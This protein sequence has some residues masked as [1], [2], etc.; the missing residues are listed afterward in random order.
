MTLTP[1]RIAEDRRTL[2]DRWYAEGFYGAQTLGQQFLE[3]VEA[4][5]DASYI[6]AGEQDEQALSLEAIAADAIR[7]CLGLRALGVR[8]GDVVAVQVPNRVELV[9][10]YYG[11]WLAGAVVVPITHIYGPMEMSFILRESG[12]KVL[13]VPDRWHHIDFVERISGLEPLPA[14]E[15]VV[16]IGE[17][18]PSGGVRWQELLERGDTGEYQDPGV[19]A[20]DVCCLI[21]TSGTTSSPKGVQHTHNTF[22]TE[23]RG[24]VSV[25][26]L[27]AGHDSTLVTFPAG[28]VAGTIS[29]CAPS[30]NGVT[31]VLMDRWDPARAVQLIERYR[32]TRTSGT[33]L[34]FT[35]MMEKAAETGTDIS[36]LRYGIVGAASVPPSLVERADAREMVLAR[37]YGSTEHP[38]VTACD[39]TD[40][41]HHRAR[42]DGRPWPGNEIRIV[43]EQ[44][45]DLPLGVDGE[46]VTRGPDMF[47]GYHDA[48]L[49]LDAF[50]PGGWY[51][52]GDIAR[53][54][55]DGYLTI[56][57]R[58]KD[59][60]IRGGEN[61]ASKEVEDL[62]MRH[63]SVAATAVVARPDDKYGET[64]A[65][66]VR[67]EPGTVL[68]LDDLGE[69]FKAAGVARQK[70]PETLIVVDEL[71]YTASGKIQ[72]V[73]LRKQLREGVLQ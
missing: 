36:S 50:L 22:L 62:I 39:A 53:V 64:V 60:I 56:T 51:R 37:C 27:E 11:A 23:F 17:G 12:A 46:L 2:R 49:D 1:E 13:V 45:Q 14:L 70:T 16:Y 32:C 35:L 41:V 73:A 72:K 34:H 3:A 25:D 44:G 42:T 33:P 29:I 20:D 61:I 55:A 5:P 4:R 65:A 9:V 67:L 28:H 24:I 47:V 31:A 10:S 8:P 38:T 69:H 7:A 58:L 43:D 40:T 71:P 63:P 54:D 15:H 26:G 30:V 57:D 52:T 19:H 59:I 66:F 68:S 48:R 21:Y 6:F 18:A